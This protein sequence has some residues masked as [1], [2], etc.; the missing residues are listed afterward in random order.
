MFDLVI[1]GGKV[2]DGTGSPWFYA[3]VGV[4]GDRIA[5]IG[6]IDP[7]DYAAGQVIDAAGKAVAPGFVDV[8]THSDYSIVLYPRADSMV[9][10]GVTTVING[11]C[12]S[13]AGP[14]KSVSQH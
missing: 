12:G 1:K 9:R 4:K 11:N 7:S 3:D 2:C 13:S 10:Q 8:H 5:C 6:Q 14:V